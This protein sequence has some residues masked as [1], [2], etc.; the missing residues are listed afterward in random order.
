M[1]IMICL[2]QTG[3]LTRQTESIMIHFD[4]LRSL[5]CIS[6]IANRW[7]GYNKMLYVK[8]SRLRLKRFPPPALAR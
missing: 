3:A 5:N 8:E 2:R 1:A 7:N 4:D 6:V